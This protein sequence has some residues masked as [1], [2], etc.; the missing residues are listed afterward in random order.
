[1]DYAAGWLQLQSICTVIVSLGLSFVVSSLAVSA[2]C[3][4]LHGVLLGKLVVWSSVA[5]VLSFPG[6]TALQRTSASE[7]GDRLNIKYHF[8]FVYVKNIMLECWSS[9]VKATSLREFQYPVERWD[10][11]PVWQALNFR[12]RF[13]C[14]V[15]LLVFDE[16]L[17]EVLRSF[18]P[19]CYQLRGSFAIA[20][21][22]NRG[23]QVY[24][25]SKTFF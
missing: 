25:L 14:V 8:W 15:S 20:I 6:K 18:F 7:L 12:A 1:M 3:S 16:E 17:P 13:C 24:E 21:Y 19:W 10:R 11:Y 23:I 22:L 5:A 4:M 9:L 2:E